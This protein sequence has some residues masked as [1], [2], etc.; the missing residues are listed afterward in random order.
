[1]AESESG[2]ERQSVDIILRGGT[3]LTM[4]ATRDVLTPGSCPG[5][6]ESCIVGCYRFQVAGN[7]LQ[8]TTPLKP[9]TWNLSLP[10]SKSTELFTE[11]CAR[12]DQFRLSGYDRLSPHPGGASQHR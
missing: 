10:N 1:M 12:V 8:S 6:W 11:F 2:I 3:V 5:F 9:V 4:N 7:R